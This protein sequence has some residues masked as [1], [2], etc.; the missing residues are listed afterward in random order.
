MKINA[1]TN[2]AFL[3]PLLNTIVTFQFRLC[4][5]HAKM[6]ASCYIYLEIDQNAR[7]DEK[8]D[9][10][11]NG[12]MENWMHIYHKKLI[13]S[14]LQTDTDNTNVF[15]NSADLVET[16]RYEPSHQN[17]HCLTSYVVFL[18]DIPVCSS[19]HVQIQ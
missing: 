9:R 1:R 4:R 16:A 5:A 8:V 17:H 19:R 6:F 13:L 7:V 12:W 15:K 11:L 3:K 18:N 14:V 2:Q 10:Q